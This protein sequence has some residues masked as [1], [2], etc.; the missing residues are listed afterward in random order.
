MASFANPLRK[1]FESGSG[2]QMA[3]IQSKPPQPTTQRVQ[4]TPNLGNPYAITEL[5]GNKKTLRKDLKTSAS[6]ADSFGVR[7]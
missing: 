1:S 5:R 6:I 2:M 7:G 4:M 3:G